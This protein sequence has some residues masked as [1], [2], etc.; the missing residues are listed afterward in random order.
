MDLLDLRGVRA[1]PAP[2]V[3]HWG[4]GLRGA[5]PGERLYASVLEDP[6]LAETIDELGDYR[7]GRERVEVAIFAFEHG[8]R[9]AEACLCE[10]CGLET[11]LCRT[12]FVKALGHRAC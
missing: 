6:H 10:Q 11:E 7:L 9:S 12:A 4:E 5:V 8:R 3:E 2:G 1:A